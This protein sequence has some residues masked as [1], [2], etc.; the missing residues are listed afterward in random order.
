MGGP[1]GSQQAS[2]YAGGSGESPGSREPAAPQGVV[3][4]AAYTSKGSDQAPPT[5]LSYQ[6]EQV[7]AHPLAC[8]CSDERA[9]KRAA[10]GINTRDGATHDYPTAP[11]AGG[12]RSPSSPSAGAV[13]IV[14][15]REDDDCKTID[16]EAATPTAGGSS[17]DNGGGKVRHSISSS[18]YHPPS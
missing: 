14:R 5:S 15:G 12:A 11:G 9:V 16:Y 8:G 3:L 4:V 10:G 18:A 17:S 6:A 7:L 13:S 2:A 1:K